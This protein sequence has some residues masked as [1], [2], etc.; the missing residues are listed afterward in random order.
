M[1]P[2]KPKSADEHVARDDDSIDTASGSYWAL[3]AQPLQALVFLLPLIVAYEIGA[4]LLLGDISLSAHRHLEIFLRLFGITGLYLPGI[5][6]IAIL[7]IWHVYRRDSWQLRPGVYAGMAA[8]S[9]TL[10]IPLVVFSLMLPQLEQAASAIFVPLAD[11]PTDGLQMSYQQALVLSVGA[12]IYEELV[13]RVVGIAL[14]H[15]IVVDVI[16]FDDFA[17]Y[18]IA[19][20][21]TAL[22]FAYFHFGPHNPFNLTLGVFYTVAGLYFAG[23]YV[24]RGLGIAAATHA[25]YDAIV[26]VLLPNFMTTG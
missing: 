14:V 15:A 10:A 2:T 20:P 23:L 12:G 11:A 17:G 7:L 16:G 4:G 13:F 25:V 18:A 21:L 6:L 9:V 3:A 5:V 1:P 26:L 22:A 8:E 19:I 24:L